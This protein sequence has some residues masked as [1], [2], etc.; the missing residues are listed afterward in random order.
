MTT[1]WE[2]RLAALVAA[3][4]D[5]G[6]LR[7]TEWAEAFAATPRHLFTPEVIITTPTGY[8]LL[9]G[10]NPASRQEWL[11]A[12]YSDESL[13][14]QDKPHAGGHL[15][16]SGEP[17]RVP[18]SSSTMPS[19]M[20][21]ML[22]ALDIDDG[23]R[24]LEIGTGTGYNA[25]LLSHRLGE[26]NVVS[27]DI[28]PCL[29]KQAAHRIAQLGYTPTLLAGDGA[30]GAAEHGPYDRIIATAAVPA[31]PIAWIQQLTPGGKIL[32]NLRGDLAGGTLCLVTKT[33]D[34]DEMIGPFLP[35]GGHFM[36]LRPNCRGPSPR[37]PH[38][39]PPDL[40]HH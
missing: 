35:I 17:L 7:S 37:H 19:L 24:I 23:M 32:A 13:V 11:S 29:I 30:A 8:R 31:I 18:T 36:W 39:T 27:I 1:D 12:V 16:S 22:E 33:D 5:E 14:T 40:G 38:R 21:R 26:D 34:D 2:P 15:L 3:S 28:D 4:A 10:D 9:S 25:A 6:D 20:A